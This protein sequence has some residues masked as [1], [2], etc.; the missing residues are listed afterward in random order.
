MKL[1]RVTDHQ[2]YKSLDPHGQ[3]CYKLGLPIPFMNHK[4]RDMVFMD[5]TVGTE[6]PKLVSAPKQQ[7]HAKRIKQNMSR[8]NPDLTGILGCYSSPTD[9]A[10]FECGG[11]IFEACVKAGMSAI[12]VSAARI[13]HEMYEIPKSDAYLIYGISDLPNPNIDRPLTSFLYERDGSLRIL[14]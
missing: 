14:V 13:A 9:T 4:I 11:S 5:Y 3:L 6:V 2:I 8:N 7:R 12:C 10:A 1:L